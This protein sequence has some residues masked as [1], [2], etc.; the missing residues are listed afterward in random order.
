MKNLK[1]VL[2]SIILI[3]SFSCSETVVK[4]VPLEST[5]DVPAVS[6]YFK[7][8]VLIEDYTGTWCGYCTRVSQA[9]D[10]VPTVTDKTVTVAIHGGGSD[11]WVTSNTAILKQYFF[12]ANTTKYPEVR[13]NRTQLWTVPE[14]LN[15]NDVKKLTG[16]NCG[17][18]LAIS[19]KIENGILNVDAKIKFAQTY[20]ENL[21]LVVYVVENNLI[22]DQTNYT[23]SYYGGQDPIPNYVHNHVLRYSFTNPLGDNITEST[24]FGLTITK[25][26][27]T[28]IPLTLPFFITNPSEIGI[29]AFV[30]NAN[31][32]VINVR[33]ANLNENQLF[34][35][36]L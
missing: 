28:T 32:T 16:N 36:N 27:N 33:Y 19:S 8:R 21:R 11:P 34:E 17:L 15:L 31:N 13:L 1:F 9:I 4:E 5:V 3:I 22:R 10:L 7:K 20:S 25:N 2:Y 14:S 29:V 26:F 24:L 35:Q 18:G 30:I 12:P 6:G 23:S